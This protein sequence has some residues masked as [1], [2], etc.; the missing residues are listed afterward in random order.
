MIDTCQRIARSYLLLDGIDSPE[1]NDIESDVERWNM[2]HPKET[3]GL[4]YVTSCVADAPGVFVAP[5]DCV[6][7]LPDAIGS[8]FPRPL[9]SLGT[10]SFGRGGSQAEL[11]K[12]FDVGDRHVA[13]ANLYALSRR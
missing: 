8:K 7:A 13:L 2:M 4:P 6:K 3:P 10:D 5:S 12:F 9:I 11:C 1:Q